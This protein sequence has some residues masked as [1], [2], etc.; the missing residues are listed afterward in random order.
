MQDNKLDKIQ[1]DVTEIKVS[2][3]EFKAE[4]HVILKTNTD[5]LVEH[6]K[7]TTLAEQRISTLEDR[8]NQFRGAWLALGFFSALILALHQLGILQRLL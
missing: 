1:E 4:T 2:L 8:D 3:A 7:R 6:V 5:S